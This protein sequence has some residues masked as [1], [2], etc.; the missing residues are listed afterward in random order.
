MC[1]YCVTHITHN[2]RHSCMLCTR[3]CWLW[4]VAKF[5]GDGSNWFIVI[6]GLIE[7]SWSP[8]NQKHLKVCCFCSEMFHCKSSTRP[9]KQGRTGR[10]IYLIYRIISKLWSPRFEYSSVAEGGQLTSKV[11]WS[12]FTLVKDLAGYKISDF[13]DSSSLGENEGPQAAHAEPHRWSL[14]RTLAYSFVRS[15]VRLCIWCLFS[16]AWMVAC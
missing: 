12:K 7:T 5:H 8:D 15:V 16:L 9:A 11:A 10:L 1:S 2:K 14:C 6:F 13:F 3:C 4:P